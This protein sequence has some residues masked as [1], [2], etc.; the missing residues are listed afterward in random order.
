MS[1]NER[2]NSWKEIANY[3]NREIRTCQRWENK[4]GLPIYRINK[5]STHSKVFAFKS[6]INH[7]FKERKK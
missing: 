2:L 7:W 5:E 4:F 1:E 3:V 6:E